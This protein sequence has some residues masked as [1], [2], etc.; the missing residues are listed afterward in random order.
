MANLATP[1]P[2]HSLRAIRWK[3]PKRTY[4][5][6]IELG[7][8]RMAASL[9]KPRSAQ[10]QA[11]FGSAPVPGK[12]RERRKR[13]DGATNVVSVLSTMIASADLVRGLVATPAAEGWDR[14][15]WYDVDVLA[16]G[17]LVPGERG[18]RRTE[19]AAAE[20][21]AQGFIRSIAWRVITNE[22]VRAVPG[23]KFITDKLW[24]A[25][26]LWDAVRS[27]R[28]RRRQRQGDAK[29][30]E[31]EAVIGGSVKRLPRT[32]TQAVPTRPN[33]PMMP[34]FAHPPPSQAGPLSTSE[35][36]AAEIA[37]LKKILGE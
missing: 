3:H 8:H 29:K 18:L 25:L 19:R 4:P 22:G 28:R 32:T 31:L 12:D 10:W 30:A 17:P 33:A 16:F 21:E 6:V 15:T 34:A 11:L 9:D 14:K 1:V 20:L 13:S 27:E 26:G 36:A 2:I 24:K 37:K 5:N 35:A 7:L 23:L